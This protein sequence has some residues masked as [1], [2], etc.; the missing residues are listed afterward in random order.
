[1][2]TYKGFPDKTVYKLEARNNCKFND[3]ELINYGTPVLLGLFDSISLQ[4]HNTS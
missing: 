4:K 3:N 1:M 2:M